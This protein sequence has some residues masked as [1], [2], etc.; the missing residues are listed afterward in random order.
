MEGYKNTGIRRYFV[1]LNHSMQLLSNVYVFIHILGVQCQHNS[2]SSS[3]SQV[4]VI[5]PLPVCHVTTAPQAF[6]LVK[7]LTGRTFGKGWHWEFPLD[8]IDRDWSLPNLLTKKDSIR[9]KGPG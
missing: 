9:A 4:T 2:R 1:F 5:L 3:N 6:Y 7:N 8:T